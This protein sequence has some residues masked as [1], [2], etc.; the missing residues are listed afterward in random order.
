MVGVLI[1]GE[2][3]R[4]GRADGLWEISVLSP[5]FHYEP[6]TALKNEVLKIKTLY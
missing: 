4:V 2:A 3:V 1:V 5:H 6:K